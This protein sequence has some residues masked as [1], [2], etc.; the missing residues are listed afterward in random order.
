MSLGEIRG[1]NIAEGIT[2]SAPDDSVPAAFG[3]PDGSNDQHAV[4][5]NYL[6]SLG[7]G[8]KNNL[9]ATVDPTA[10]DDSASDYQVGSVWW[11]VTTGVVWRAESVGV[12][13]AVWRAPMMLHGAQTVA[14]AKT[15]SDVATF[16]SGII[17]Q[18]SLANVDTTNLDVK[19]Q[20]VTINKGGNDAT[21]EDSGIEVERASTNA[22]IK[23]EDALASKFKAGP[24]GSESELMTVA[25]AQ[26]IAGKKTHSATPR[27]NAAQEFQEILT[28]SLPPVNHHK[29][30]PK[31]DGNFYKLN[32]SGVESQLGGGSGVGG[33]NLLSTD[34]FDSGISGVVKYRNTVNADAPDDFG[35][36]APTDT[37]LEL[38]H[39][40]G[41]PLRGLGSLRARKKTAVDLQ[42]SGWYIE[43]ETLS[44]AD[45]GR[46]LTLNYLLRSSSGYNSGLI[47][48]YIV[49]STDNFVADFQVVAFPQRDILASDLLPY[50]SQLQIDTSKV[51]GKARICWHLTSDSSIYDIDIDGDPECM[52]GP[53]KASITADRVLF[54]GEGNGGGALTANVTDVDFTQVEANGG[55]WDG[56]GYTAD[57]DEVI[58]L[59]GC[60]GTSPG[61]SALWY[62]YIDGTLS[63]LLIND[64]VS[65][66][67]HTFSTKIKLNR[68]ERLS[69]RSNTGATLNNTTNEH[70]ITITARKGVTSSVLFPNREISGEA[71]RVAN[72]SLINASV[73]VI[74]LN[75]IVTDTIGAWDVI[76]NYEY[77]AKEKG[78]YDVEA[79]IQYAAN[80]TG[81]RNVGFR[82]IRPS[83]TTDIYP[84]QIGANPS[85]GAS[86]ICPGSYAFEL[87]AGDKVRLLGFQASGGN[88]NVEVARMHIA[89]RATSQ[90]ILGSEKVLTRAY[91]GSA[92]NHTSVGGF[93]K[94]PIDTK[95]HDTFS[96]WNSGGQRIDITA[97]D[98]YDLNAQIAFDT[99]SPSKRGQVSIY[100]NGSAVVYG[101]TVYSGGTGP[102]YSNATIT[103][104]LNKGDYVELFAFQDDTASEAYIVGSPYTYLEVNKR[105]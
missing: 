72:Q 98:F 48:Q 31:A 63:K 76:T 86:T 105:N 81:S 92:A 6:N 22:A 99:I 87:D 60:I 62:V 70:Y 83:G 75:T 10:T 42:G 57:E 69:I 33:V 30:Y 39:E 23:H 21:S 52:F 80:A 58:E 4:T 12:G 44:Q 82:V 1:S 43:T 26:T 88:L 66:Q 94:V 50:L 100:V 102:Q 61:V 46:A 45:V 101:T 25:A 36:T 85:G 89:K 91:L 97:P 74:Q 34:S 28:P 19:D 68:G 71:E 67:R 16:S 56:S 95:D 47:R 9:T 17:V 65:L 2:I 84:T 18:G 53:I 40:T 51:G 14:G 93:Q 79:I 90:T 37:D 20:L 54:R 27:Y 8:A 38:V 41:S 103:K 3:D 49:V 78:T 32:S 15:F 35:G 77:E 5:V 55:Q 104:F 7:A 24:V 29:F 59:M 64:A 96:N 13:T 11:N 73:T